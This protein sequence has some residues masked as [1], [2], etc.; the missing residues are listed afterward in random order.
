[1]FNKNITSVTQGTIGLGIAIAWFVENGYIVSLPLNDNQSYD[2]VVDNGNGLKRVQV[3]TTRFKANGCSNYIVNLKTV[4]ANKNENKI[5]HFSC[6]DCDFVFIVT[7]EKTKYLI[8][9]IEI[10]ILNTIN[11]GKKVEKWKV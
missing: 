3:K 5:K 1:M 6:K 8:P 2:I 9:S 7:E 11:L 10:D 4:R